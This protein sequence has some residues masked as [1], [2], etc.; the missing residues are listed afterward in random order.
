MTSR[1]TNRS[2]TVAEQDVLGFL[3]VGLQG[4]VRSGGGPGTG[5]CRRRPGPP[6]GARPRRG[7]LAEGRTTVDISGLLYLSHHTVRNHVRNILGKLD[8]RSQLEAVVI[9]SSMGLVSV[10]RDASD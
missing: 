6:C 10:G 9:A 7:G 1:R 2:S 5:C 4:R 3:G 8:A